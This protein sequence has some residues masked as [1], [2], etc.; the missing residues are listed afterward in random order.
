MSSPKRDWQFSEMSARFLLF[1]AAVSI[2]D[3]KRFL[4][5]FLELSYDVFELL[6]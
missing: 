2:A 1:L 4:V 3:F 6:L 5:I